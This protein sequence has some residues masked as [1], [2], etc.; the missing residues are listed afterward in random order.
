MTFNEAM[1]L[2]ERLVKETRRT[3][4]VIGNEA[5]YRVIEWTWE[6]KTEQPRKAA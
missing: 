6:K 5:P 3:W 2:A 4:A 1:T